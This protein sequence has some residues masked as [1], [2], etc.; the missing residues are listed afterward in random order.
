LAPDLELRGY[1]LPLPSAAPGGTLPLTLY[2]TAAATPATDYTAKLQLRSA[3]GAT[4]LEQVQPIGGAYPTSQ[5]AAETTLRDWQDLAVPLEVA[6]GVYRLWLTVDGGEQG[7]NE[8]DLGEITVEGRPHEFDP[9]AIATPITGSFGGAVELLGLE[10]ALPADA[11]P[12][13]TL[14]V[15]LVWQVSQPQERALVRF[16]HL[17]DADGRPVAQQDSVPCAGECPAGTWLTNEVLRDSVTLTIP[18]DTAD[19]EYTLAV[20]WYDAETLQRLDARDGDGAAPPDQI[21]RLGQVTL[22]R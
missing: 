7:P 15:P 20:G 13:A 5:W 12:G 8:L 21:L 14:N 4:V 2:W 19:G 16:V 22:L 18:P 17:L 10:Q 9:P 1:D 11:A 3:D 6:N